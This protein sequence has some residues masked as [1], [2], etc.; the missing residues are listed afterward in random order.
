ME[1]DGD[2]IY[3]ETW[4]EYSRFRRG[5]EGSDSERFLGDLMRDHCLIPHA[6]YNVVCLEYDAHLPPK[7]TEE[8]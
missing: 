5:V 8:E 3:L 1:V 4:N 6:T 2:T 7:S